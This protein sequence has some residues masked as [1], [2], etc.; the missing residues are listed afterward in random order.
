V[1]ALGGVPSKDTGNREFKLE[2]QGVSACLAGDE[3]KQ[4]KRDNDSTLEIY[5]PAVGEFVERFTLG[6][7]RIED[8]SA[9]TF[10]WT[11]GNTQQNQFG[12]LSRSLRDS[13]LRLDCRQG[14]RYVIL[15]D[16][17]TKSKDALSLIEPGP[18]PKGFG[19][20]RL[21]RSWAEKGALDDSSWKLC[22]R[23]WRIDVWK[24][25]D[26]SVFSEG[27]N[28]KA[29]PVIVEDIIPRVITL[30]IKV[31][32]ERVDIELN[33][34]EQQIDQDRNRWSQILQRHQ[35]K[36]SFENNPSKSESTPDELTKLEEEEK[37]LRRR[38]DIYDSLMHIK[39]ATLSLS[40]GLS[41][42]ETTVIDL[43]TL[44][45]FEP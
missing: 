23:R 34:D 3:L 20:R 44:G 26:K 24:Q 6:V 28:S 7:F 35:P 16:S 43:A 15:R 9:L 30:T 22:I 1:S 29:S 33:F 2:I 32:R 5:R 11:K 4:E 45:S 37:E 36:R 8:N 31:E 40:I 25:N 13:V 10:E 27:T 21:T 42:D 18:Q 12:R 17:P 19:T 14:P 39:N 41:I 38:I